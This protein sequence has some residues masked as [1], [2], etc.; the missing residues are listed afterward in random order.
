[1]PMPGTCGALAADAFF[2]SVA[3][4][5]APLLDAP[6]DGAGFC[7]SYP[8]EM[9]ADGD[10]VPL[11]FSK[12]VGLSDLLGRPIGAGLRD[13]LARAGVKGAPRFTLL[14]D[15]VSTLLCAF[16]QGGARVPSKLDAAEGQGDKGGD[17]V[18]A[19][20][21]PVIGMIL[22]TGFNIAYC[23]KDIPKIGFRADEGTG[24]QAVVCESGAF[25]FRYQ[26]VLDRE[27]DAGTM[28]PGAFTTEKVC[29][30]AYL[31]PLSL[32]VLKQ[33]VRDGVLHFRRSAELLNME[34]LNTKDL[35]ALLRAPLAL[36]GPVG[37][38][39]NTDETDALRS[40]VYIESVLTER[41][42]LVAAS[43]L[44]AVA[45]RCGADDP[46]APVRAAVEGTT[47]SVYHFLGEAFRAR[48]HCALSGGAPRFCVLAPVEQASL[49]GA[50]AA[51]LL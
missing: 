28:Y 29:A 17:R 30:G 24:G 19:A 6:V 31:G 36:R 11:E 20:E 16:T 50:A 18:N 34:T 15:T 21:G 3:A 23:E 37:G 2:D 32:V 49:A 26:G 5:C 22:G 12:E 4:F 13:A 42:A 45:E 39:V 38:L 41:A 8:M 9:T 10:G 48:L 7:F 1:M 27:F 46:L 33:A 51:A 35:N 47:F 14:N 44:A 43:A 25:R 40:L